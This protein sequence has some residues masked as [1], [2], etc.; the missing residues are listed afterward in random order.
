MS[1][2]YKQKIIESKNEIKINSSPECGVWIE[3]LKGVWP[4]LCKNVGISQTSP[5]KTN[6]MPVA[7]KGLYWVQVFIFL[8]LIIHNIY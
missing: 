5:V 8:H 1:E 3:G 4:S 2:L 7:S 6:I